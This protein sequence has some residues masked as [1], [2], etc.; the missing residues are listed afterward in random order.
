MTIHKCV[1]CIMEPICSKPLRNFAN[2]KLYLEKK[3]KLNTYLDC[4]V[5]VE[6]LFVTQKPNLYTPQEKTEKIKH[7]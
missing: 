5:G 1:Q 3:K 4:A 6:I 2:F 7:Q